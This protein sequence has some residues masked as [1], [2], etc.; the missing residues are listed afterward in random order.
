[1]RELVYI[2]LSFAHVCSVFWSA[3][4]LS[5]SLPTASVLHL[6]LAQR[7]VVLQQLTLLFWD[8][9]TT[10]LRTCVPLPI[11]ANNTLLGVSPTLPHLGPS[12]RTEQ[13]STRAWQHRLTTW[14]KHE[15]IAVLR[16]FTN[17]HDGEN[18]H[19]PHCI[20]P[21]TCDHLSNQ[22]TIT[23]PHSRAP[24]RLSPSRVA[25]VPPSSHLWHSDQNLLGKC[26]HPGT[27]PS[28]SMFHLTESQQ[29]ISRVSFL[30]GRC[31]PHPDSS[32][33][34]H[35]KTRMTCRCSHRAWL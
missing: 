20:G 32:R 2:K 3:C 31:Y 7:L 25:L 6:D 1:M 24:D 17:A 10:V 9:G 33:R 14:A 26:L 15:P 16:Y 35:W 29:W 11:M 13:L 4:F 23:F 30:P 5:L 27:C 34:A 8:S 12:H 21:E 22:N 28:S 18:S 19:R